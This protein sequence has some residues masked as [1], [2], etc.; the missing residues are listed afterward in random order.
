M[1]KRIISLLQCPNN[2]KPGFSVFAS[3]LVRNGVL[4]KNLSDSEIL[5]EDD[6]KQGVVLSQGSNTAYPIS[7]FIGVFLNDLDADKGHHK[8]L[9]EPLID[10]CP[11]VFNEGIK[12]TLAR[13]YGSAETH[14]GNWNREEMKY[15]DAEVDTEDLRSIMLKSINGQPVWRIFI[16]RR[17]NIIEKIA[18]ECVGKNVLEI[19][20]GNSRTVAREFNPE[21]FNYNYIGTDISFKRLL[22]AKSAIPAADFLQ[23]SAI[24]LPFKD[25]SFKALISF[26]M[27]HH[28]P[29]PVDALKEADKKIELNGLFG[30]HEPV[31]TSRKFLKDNA[32]IQKMFTTYE[33]SEHDNKIDLEAS[34]KELKLL[35]HTV[36]NK[37]PYNSVF[38][39][40]LESL[41]SKF[42]KKS[43]NS[44]TFVSAML[45]V[46]NVILK[47]ICKLSNALGPQGIIIV[48]RKN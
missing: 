2:F 25:N 16:P 26:G 37:V 46:D 39:V 38:R 11:D 30:F 44:L 41:L 12:T 47:T 6:I 27:L 14:D 17:K 9:F 23:A 24:N 1:H 28:L 3:E 19:G 15:Y 42:Y 43:F 36:I 21:K 10:K 32:V 31:Y 22:V 8:N 7:N 13:I 35:N 48:S 40:V 4:L 29:R 45:S 18:A 20:C 34:L 5:P 33:H